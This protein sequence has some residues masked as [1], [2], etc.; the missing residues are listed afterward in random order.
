MG[1]LGACDS[2]RVV[3]GRVVL[4]LEPVMIR[5]PLL[6]SWCSCIL[7]RY[8][9]RARTSHVGRNVLEGLAGLYVPLQ[10]GACGCRGGK[11]SRVGGVVHISS[12]R[13]A[14]GFSLETEHRLQFSFGRI[15]GRGPFVLLTEHGT[16]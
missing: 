13:T 1:G 6:R 2:V 3:Q 9:K 5:V 15:Q 8:H 7:V 12:R 11:D 4:L 10:P 16:L 14:L